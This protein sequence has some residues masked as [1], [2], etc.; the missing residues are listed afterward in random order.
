MTM[1]TMFKRRW[2]KEKPGIRTDKSYLSTDAVEKIIRETLKGKLAQGF[3]L[4]LGDGEYYC[5]P[6]ADVQEILQASALDRKTWVEERFDC[7][8]F[9]YVLKAHFCEAAYTDGQ[10]RAAHCFGIVWGM[11]PGPHAINWVISQD[12][13]VMGLPPTPAKQASGPVLYFVEPQNDKIYSPRVDDTSIWMMI[14]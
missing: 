11:L 12:I 2:H 13:L 5:P 3:D 6:I 9:A 4:Y 14:A 1:K 8:D 10:R 7:D